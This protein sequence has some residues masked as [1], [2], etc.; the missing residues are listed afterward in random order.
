MP[1]HTY[2]D[3]GMTIFHTRLQE[4]MTQTPTAP[5]VET[6]PFIT[7]SRE[8]CAG[9]ST[10][11]QLLL[12]KL[13]EACGK[14]N[15]SWMFLDKN[16]L[17][18]ALSCHDLPERLEEYLPEDRISEINA[19]IGEL[20]GLHPPLW[21]LEHQ[22]SETIR[23]LAR[24][25]RVIFAG[26]AAHLITRSLPGGFHI[27]L[28]AGKEIRIE[29][30]MALKSCDRHAAEELIGYSDLARHR[31][32]KKNFGSEI[33]DPHAYDLVLNTDRLPAPAVAAIVLEGLRQRHFFR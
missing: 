4:P 15:Q 5:A 18:Y 10:L 11:G 3:R 21:E 6:A 19:I 24:S 12:P 26:R 25:G 8:A 31:F 28:V 33:D 20:V 13:D 23:Q 1:S 30:M 7:I 2:L 29:R 17:H 22:I 14:E 9:A 16:L 32:V 27:R